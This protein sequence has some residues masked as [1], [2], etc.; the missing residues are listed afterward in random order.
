M[1][2]PC[3]IRKLRGANTDAEQRAVHPLQILVDVKGRHSAVYLH[4]EWTY[5]EDWS[6][7]NLDGNPL[8]AVKLV[9]IIFFPVDGI[10]QV[11]LGIVLMAVTVTFWTDRGSYWYCWWNWTWSR[12]RGSVNLLFIFN[13]LSYVWVHTTHSKYSISKV[14]NYLHNQKINFF[15]P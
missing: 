14:R 8:E 15:R 10:N 3:N 1:K 4:I 9:I 2:N 6:I 12:R 7:H 5:L 13:I 11:A